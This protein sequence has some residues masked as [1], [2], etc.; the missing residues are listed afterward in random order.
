DH[1]G[2][3]PQLVRIVQQG[4]AQQHISRLEQVLPPEYRQLNSGILESDE[5]PRVQSLLDLAELRRQLGRWPIDGERDAAG[6][7]LSLLFPTDSDSLRQTPTVCNKLRQFSTNSDSLQQTRTVFNKLGQFATNSD[8]LQQTPTVCDRLRQF[9]TNS[10]SLQQTRTVCN[11][12]GQFRQT[13]TVCNKLGQF[14]TNSDSFRQFST[15]PTVSDKLPIVSDKCS[16]THRCCSVKSSSSSSESSCCSSWCS[17]KNNA[18]FQTRRSSRQSDNRPIRAWQYWNTSA[19]Q[20]GHRSR[21]QDRVSTGCGRGGGGCCCCCCCCCRFGASRASVMYSSS[22]SGW[23]LTTDRPT[24]SGSAKSSR[25]LRNRRAPELR[26]G[27]RCDRSTSQSSSSS[28]AVTWSGL[29]RRLLS[30]SLS[31][32]P[33]SVTSSTL[34]GP[35][36]P[37]RVRLAAKHETVGWTEAA[38]NGPANRAAPGSALAANAYRPARHTRSFTGGRPNIKPNIID[39]TEA[40]APAPAAAGKAK[41]PRASKKKEAKPR[42]HPSYTDMIVKAIS[43]LKDRKGSSRQSITKYLRA[44]Y[45]FGADERVDAYVKAALKAGSKSGRFVHT[46]GVGASGS[47]ALGEKSGKAG[48]A[49][50]RKA[51]GAKRKAS[52]KK[53]PSAAAK[54]PAG[55]KKASPAK[56]RP[57]AAAATAAPAAAAA[58]PAAA[59]AA[60]AAA[61]KPRRSAGAKKPK[62]AAAGGAKKKPAA[63][64]KK[65]AKPKAAKAKK[66][67][68]S[69]KKKA[70]KKNQ[71]QRVVARLARP[72]RNAVNV[73]CV[74]IGQRLG[75]G[76]P[77]IA[78]RH[79]AFVDEDSVV[80]ADRLPAPQLAALAVHLRLFGISFGHA[81]TAAVFLSLVAQLLA[82]AHAVHIVGGAGA[83]WNAQGDMRLQRRLVQ[84]VGR[85]GAW[86][87]NGAQ[88]G[89]SLSLPVGDRHPAAIVNPIGQRQV[90]NVGEDHVKGRPV[91]RDLDAKEMRRPSGEVGAAGCSG[92]KQNVEAGHL[93]DAEAARPGAGGVGLVSLVGQPD[94]Q[95]FVL[96]VASP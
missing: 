81:M 59:A 11:K 49:S 91:H 74:T 70:A 87:D 27:R 19:F 45:K 44:N 88:L 26:L 34:V 83:A 76:L 9:S 84:G 29:S 77:W 32:S 31:S 66:P 55:A 51:A 21:I 38:P 95:Q 6:L 42:S 28:V 14:P 43:A 13:P 39:M 20:R 78:R 23:E 80:V 4:F 30:T 69:P 1:D 71:P 65:P 63:A 7:N 96:V 85:R 48:G 92:A 82:G 64:K 89:A 75:F 53:R 8:S 79:R 22:S 67:K 40:S 2:V 17:P 90:V 52:P 3:R 54:K 41:K 58:A 93:V 33:A 5:M 35:P 68:A 36:E 72:G 18:T 50:P 62:K 94:A 86:P 46:K 25:R 37:S 73:K 15:V 61:A 60:P 47:F 57:K 12:L 24:P 16:F 10:D 56:K